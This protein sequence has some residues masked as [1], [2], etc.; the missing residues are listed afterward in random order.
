MLTLGY[1]SKKGIKK[2]FRFYFNQ[3]S[4]QYVCASRSVMSDSLQPHEL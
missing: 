2:V 3:V 4:L 1:K